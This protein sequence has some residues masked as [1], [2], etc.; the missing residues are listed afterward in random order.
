MLALLL[1]AAG[2][3]AVDAERAFNRA[4]QTQGQWT[5]FRAFAAPDAVIFKPEP[6]KA[7][8]PDKDPPIAVQWWP[9]ESYVSCDGATAVNTGPWV[10][11]DSF[12]YFT[13][14]WRKQP[15]GGWKFAYDDGD[16]LA[17]PRPLPEKPKVIKASCRGNPRK[18]VPIAPIFDAAASADGQS[19]DGT[20]VW[21]WSTD[22]LGGRGMLVMIWN[23]RNW[24]EALRDEVGPAA[25]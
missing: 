20:L 4:A 16:A 13:T 7:E 2:Q 15:D 10:R 21:R 23:G 5:A 9:A 11:P 25:K 3:T 18:T 19:D 12:G 24:T 8:F 1:A 22:R 14:I 6:A 17:K